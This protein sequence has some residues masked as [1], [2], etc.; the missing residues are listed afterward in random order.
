MGTLTSCPL[1]AAEQQKFWTAP[2]DLKVE[3][4]MLAKPG[5]RQSDLPMVKGAADVADFV[6]LS[7]QNLDREYFLVIFLN[8]RQRVVGVQEQSIGSISGVEVHPREVFKSAL[9]A[10]AKV[11]ASSIIVVHNHPSGEAE[12][13]RQDIE[14]TKR[15]R[16]V[17]EIIG[18]PVLDHVVLGEGRSYVSLRDRGLL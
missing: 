12:P 11:G 18:I 14:L 17:G 6:R 2:E 8:V 16:E 10:A 13:S 9:A 7:Y 15:L 1:V 3:T 4:V 5:V